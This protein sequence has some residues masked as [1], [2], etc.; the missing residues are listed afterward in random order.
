MAGTPLQPELLATVMADRLTQAM[1][2][3]QVRVQALD[4]ALMA[5][6][7]RVRELE[8]VGATLRERLAVLET[9]APVP[10]PPG[11]DGAPGRDGMD[12]QDGVGFDD[13]SA[14]FDGDRTLTVRFQR[15]SVIKAFPVVLP[16]PRYCGYF[17]GAQTY[18]V[19]DLVTWAGQMWHC[20]APTSSKPD[21]HAGAWRLVVKKGRDGR[22]GRVEAH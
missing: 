18:R 16:I 5:A 9:R 22:D 7:D 20:Q 17:S 13:L 1:S 6:L 19:G 14:E 2:P 8:T 3:M 12:G 15:G 4:V 21:D 11:V 10:G